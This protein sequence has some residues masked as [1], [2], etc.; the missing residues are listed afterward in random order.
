MM[1]VKLRKLGAPMIVFFAIAVVAVGWV[2]F[3]LWNYTK[4]YVALWNFD[5][6]VSS[7]TVDLS[8]PQFVRV[9]VDLLVSNPTSY[10]GLSVS[11]VNYDLEYI[12]G[13]HD[14]VVPSGRGTAVISTD[15]WSLSANSL[16]KNLSL[17]PNSDR[18]ISLDVTLNPGAD[19]DTETFLVYLKT[20][21]SQVSWYLD[22]SVVVV[23]FLTGFVVERVFDN[24]A[25]P[26][27]Y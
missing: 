20:Q 12:D 21:P 13:F 23:S 7:V 14:I 22:C 25:T 8:N 5:F 4:F 24:L 11:L 1:R 9:R 2:A 3:P 27:H 19:L 26:M 18:T 16:A 10:S 17:P 6:R 15:R